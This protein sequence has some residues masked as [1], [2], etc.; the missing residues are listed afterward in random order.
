MIC[1]DYGR[2]F[3]HMFWTCLLI[4]YIFTQVV[5]INVV[6]TTGTVHLRT[7]LTSLRNQFQSFKEKN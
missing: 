1:N 6:I 5:I 7:G 4:R 3:S 2:I